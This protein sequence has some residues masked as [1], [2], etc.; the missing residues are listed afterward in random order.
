MF[1]V[2]SGVVLA[3][4]ATTAAVGL[5]IARARTSWRTEAQYETA[6]DCERRAGRGTFKAGLGDAGNP[7]ARFAAAE[8]AGDGECGQA[9]K[10]ITA[11]AIAA[12][13]TASARA[14][15]VTR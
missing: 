11:A 12:A 14:A 9:I 8:D 7:T 10:T 6:T 13:A 4:L 5:G 1:V 15:A 2:P 3:S